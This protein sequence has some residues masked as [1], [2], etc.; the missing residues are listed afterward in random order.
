[1]RNRR[2]LDSVAFRPRVLRDVSGIDTSTTLFGHNMRIPVMLAPIGSLQDIIEEGGTAPTR[3]AASFGTIHMLSSVAHPGL[4]AVAAEVDHP[5]FFQLYVRGDADWVDEILARAVDNGFAGI[6]LTVDRAHYSRRDRDVAKDH[7]P[8]A[9]RNIGAGLHQQRFSWKDVE[10]IRKNV[11]LPLM[12]KGIATIEDA[13][14]AIAHGIDGVYI[15]NHGGRQLDHCEGSVGLVREIADTV[16]GR[17][18]IIVD[19][20]ILR[21]TDVV[22]ALALG[23]QAVAI[24]RLQGIAL[25]AGGEAA[26]VRVLEILEAEMIS[27][28]GLLG[29]TNISEIG[30]EC[31]TDAPPLGRALNWI[32]SAFPLIKEGY[33]E[34]DIADLCLKLPG[35]G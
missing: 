15:S 1:N 31:I 16:A 3:A 4:E 22:K 14:M 29:V 10:R 5:K 13:E 35:E 26:M 23:A 32:D 11:N 21:G 9:R 17:A 12:L 25:A 27:D 19:G 18:S 28:M 30:P 34:T 7:A 6:A 8:T 2:A 20:T 33:G 24:G